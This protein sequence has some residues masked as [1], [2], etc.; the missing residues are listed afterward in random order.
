MRHINYLKFRM[1]FIYVFP[2]RLFSH[3]L[4]ETRS[5]NELYDKAVSAVIL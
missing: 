3:L 5:D 4:S 2:N 1:S